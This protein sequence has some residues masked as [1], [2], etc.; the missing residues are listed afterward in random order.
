MMEEIYADCQECG[1]HDIVNN[2]DNPICFECWA[3][4]DE[5]S[6]NEEE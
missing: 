4:L 2:L 1:K 6:S 5:Q 3:F